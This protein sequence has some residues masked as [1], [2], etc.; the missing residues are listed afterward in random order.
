MI[1][2]TEDLPSRGA[3]V[4]PE[5]IR[6]MIEALAKD[7]VFEDAGVTKSHFGPDSDYLVIRV[8]QRQQAGATGILARTFEAKP[9]SCGDVEGDHGAERSQ[10]VGGPRC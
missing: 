5:R 9:N 10:P 6:G 8:Y 1:L 2:C 4:K 3:A 7:G